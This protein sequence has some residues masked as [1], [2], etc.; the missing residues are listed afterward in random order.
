MPTGSERCAESTSW[1]SPIRAQHRPLR[2]GASRHLLASGETRFPRVPRQIDARPAS[3]GS[4]G[5]S[6]PPPSESTL[7][8][9]S[10]CADCFRLSVGPH[11]LSWSHRRR[12][13][14]SS[15]AGLG[16][17][18]RGMLIVSSGYRNM[19]ARSWSGPILPSGGVEPRRA[20]SGGSARRAS[21]LF[22]VRADVIDAWEEGSV[23]G[24]PSKRRSA[25][26]ERRVKRARR[27]CSDS[28]MASGRSYRR[29]GHFL[30]R[31]SRRSGD[32]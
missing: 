9:A 10:P 11:S 30:R 4:G 19:L 22:S 1:G 28:S 23:T 27:T 13:G 2:S 32:R 7:A 16:E 31:N 5:Q 14:A 25:W 20:R 17:F 24:R 3:E 29:T 12:F 21:R 18:R 6:P 26:M 15:P 8:Q